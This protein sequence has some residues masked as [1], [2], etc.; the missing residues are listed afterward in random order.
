MPDWKKLVR[1]HIASSALP[2]ASREEVVSELAAHLEEAYEAA[3]LQGLT[4][5]AA[6]EFTLQEVNDWHAL[7]AR[8]HRARSEENP[9]NNRTRSL[10]LPAMANLIV[11][12][13]WLMILQKLAV[14]PR[15]LWI[16]DMAMVLYLPWLV[17]LPIFGAFGALLAKRAH[18]RFVNRLIVGL[19]PAL[20]VLGAFALILPVSLVVDQHRLTNFP[21]A[22]FAL[23][24]FNW[25][26]LPALALLIGTL[27]FLR[28]TNTLARTEA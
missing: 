19:S 5:K 28:E 8:I 2:A 23:T 3:L 9:M 14:Q 12:P 16:G 18:A 27:P 10:W 4:E 11:A 1:E 6:V 25:V 15:V 13:G 7:A 24:I 21:F 20:A 17:T 22:Y 26:V